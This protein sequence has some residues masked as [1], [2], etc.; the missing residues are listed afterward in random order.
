MTAE[1]TEEPAKKAATARPN[2]AAPKSSSPRTCTASPPVR[3]AGS[4]VA[5]AVA[6]ASRTG[7]R[8]K[9]SRSVEAWFSA[10]A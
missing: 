4:T 8:F 7:R 2:A 9:P 3:K 6:T 1:V 10:A 5:V